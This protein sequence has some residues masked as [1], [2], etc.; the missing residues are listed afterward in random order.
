[1]KLR[2]SIARPVA[3]LVSWCLLGVVAIAADPT[4][5]ARVRLLRNNEPAAARVSIVAGDGMPIAPVG[6]PLRKTKREESYFYADGSFAV[7]MPPGRAR[8]HVSV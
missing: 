7:K 3:G 1:M 8:L 5:T 6:A 4:T 2:F